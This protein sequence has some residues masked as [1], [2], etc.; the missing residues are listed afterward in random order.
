MIHDFF[1]VAAM[2]AN[3]FLEQPREHV[4][5]TLFQLHDELVSGYLMHKYEQRR[6]KS[7]ASGTQTTHTWSLDTTVIRS[8]QM[9]SSAPH[10]SDNTTRIVIVTNSEQLLHAYA[11]RSICFMEETGLAA[12]RAFDGNDFQATHI[13]VY[14]NNEPIGASRIRWFNG[15][16]KFERTGFRQAYRNVRVIKQTAEF[17]FDHV[18]R[19]GYSKVVTMAKPK[20]AAIWTR[21][22]GFHEVTDRPPTLSGEGEPFLELVKDLTTPADAISIDTDPNVLFRVEGSWHVPCAFEGDDM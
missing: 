17:M 13:V 7:V 16:A 3:G 1:P 9:N 21:V 4:Q 12:R 18:A 19:K 8:V 10:K 20:Y 15:F 22:L 2:E 5:S 6:F 14:A 11:V